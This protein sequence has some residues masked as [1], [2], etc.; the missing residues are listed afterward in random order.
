M[1]PL[2]LT[3]ATAAMAFTFVVEDGTGKDDA[4]SYVTVAEADDYLAIVPESWFEATAWSTLDN[5]EKEKALAL[6]ARLL[7]QKTK[8]RGSKAVEDSALRWPRVGAYDRDGIGVGSN[9]IPVQVKEAA[10]EMAKFLLSSNLTEG[11][12]VDY[13]KSIE[14]DVISL[15]YQ[16]ET[17]QSTLPSIINDILM[18]LGA[19]VTGGSR[20]IRIAK[21]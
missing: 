17:G 12:N 7:D 14:V 16:D 6:G 18:G 19:V 8:W 3:K 9:V 10:I 4:T 5:T 15:T 21:S 2:N 13:L 1:L 11:Q 20:F